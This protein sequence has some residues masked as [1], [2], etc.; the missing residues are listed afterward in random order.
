MPVRRRAAGAADRHLS[1][2]PVQH[3]PSPG[4]A[5]AMHLILVARYY[6]TPLLNN[7]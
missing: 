4:N 3:H 1:Q 6:C 5:A 7:S 2:P